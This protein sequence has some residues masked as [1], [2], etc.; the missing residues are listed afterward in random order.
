MKTTKSSFKP[1]PLLMGTVISLTAL[2][3]AFASNETSAREGEKV[4]ICHKPNDPLQ[5]QTMEIPYSALDAHLKHGDY[6]GTCDSPPDPKLN[7]IGGNSE[8]P[9]CMELNCHGN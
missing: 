2:Y 6:I 9:D 5:A 1:I 7:D 8:S 4:T 3:F